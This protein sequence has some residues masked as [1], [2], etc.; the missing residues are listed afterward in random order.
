MK[1]ITEK[2]KSMDF[3]HQLWSKELEAL[4][5]EVTLYEKRIGELAEQYSSLQEEQVLGGFLDEFIS[6]RAEVNTLS[7]GVREHSIKVL[8]LIRSNGHVQTIIGTAHLSTRESIMELRK[9]YSELKERFHR[10]S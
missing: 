3:D 10:F 9:N 2:L 8:D 7:K 6:L 5:E 4:N 1:E